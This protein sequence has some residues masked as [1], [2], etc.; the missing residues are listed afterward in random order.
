MYEQKELHDKAM[1]EMQAL[2]NKLSDEVKEAVAKNKLVEEKL[3]KA[4][5]V[6]S[7]MYKG[8]NNLEQRVIQLEKC[9]DSGWKVPKKYIFALFQR[10]MDGQGCKDDDDAT[11]DPVQ[12][13]ERVFGDDLPEA[14]QTGHAG[15]SSSQAPPEQDTSRSDPVSKVITLSNVFENI[16]VSESE[17]DTETDSDSSQTQLKREI[18]LKLGHDKSEYANAMNDMLDA[19]DPGSMKE[20]L[21]P[22]DASSE[23]SSDS[24]FEKELMKKK[25][26]KHK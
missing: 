11:K 5:F 21:E 24:D 7:K 2:V 4:E 17:Q 16:N 25:K 23:S 13:R 22:D 15:A 6:V 20:Q 19:Y 3:G 12:P 26:K 18:Y 14:D 1:A 10:F 8:C 9:V